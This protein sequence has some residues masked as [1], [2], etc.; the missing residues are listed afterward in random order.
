MEN[1]DREALLKRIQSEE[2]LDQL[3][4]VEEDELRMAPKSE[5]EIRVTVRLSADDVAL[6]DEMCKMM[7]VGRSTYLKIAAAQGRGVVTETR[8]AAGKRRSGSDVQRVVYKA[9]SAN[10]WMVRELLTR[11]SEGNVIV[12]HPGDTV[13]EEAA[14]MTGE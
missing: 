2:Y 12:V 10:E 14:T 8:L 7:G 4:E 9:S 1:L 11:L 3:V 5:R 13:S 6:V